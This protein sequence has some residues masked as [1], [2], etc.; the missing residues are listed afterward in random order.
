MAEQSTIFLHL[1]RHAKTEVNSESGKDFDRCLH[2]KGVVQANVLGNY[3]ALKNSDLSKCFVSSAKRT[4]QTA[5]I[6][7][8]ITNLG[9]IY[10]KDDLYLCGHEKFL[11]IL[12][13]E[14]SNQ[15]LLFIGH[16]DGISEIVSYF[17]D[18]HF[19]MRTC[20]YVCLAFSLDSWDQVCRGAAIISDD[21]RPNV[22]DPDHLVF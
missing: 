9:K 19:M 4:K 14:K 22:V 7:N 13:E 17:I 11:E 15:D 10:F 8:N 12:W 21:F 5:E 18:D 1:I 16:N 6:L 20:Q 2:P 3:L